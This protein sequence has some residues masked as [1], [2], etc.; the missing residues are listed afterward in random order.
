MLAHVLILFFR[1]V[2]ATVED[3]VP[4]APREQGCA[5]SGACTSAFRAD[6]ATASAIDGKR[7]SASPTSP[8][9]SC[10]SKKRLRGYPNQAGL[11]LSVVMPSTTLRR[12]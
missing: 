9:A 6:K 7:P 1:L 4:R 11:L 8:E 2:V 3:E 12:R 10:P 5:A